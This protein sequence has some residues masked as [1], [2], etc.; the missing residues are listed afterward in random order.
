MDIANY[1]L[2]APCFSICIALIADFAKNSSQYTHHIWSL[3]HRY[4]TAALELPLELLIYLIREGRFANSSK[5]NDGDHLQ[6]LWR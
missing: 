5:P 3:R 6:M 1:M 2:D 4:K